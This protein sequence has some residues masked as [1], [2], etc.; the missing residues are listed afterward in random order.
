MGYLMQLEY[1]GLQWGVLL[2]FDDI[3]MVMVI[4][5][6]DKKTYS[7]LLFVEGSVEQVIVKSRDVDGNETTWQE[8]IFVVKVVF[9]YMGLGD[10]MIE[11]IDLYGNIG[12]IMVKL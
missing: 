6:G 4:C 5:G 8:I 3:V 9:L 1:V 7:D 12:M 11:V 10:C 2:C